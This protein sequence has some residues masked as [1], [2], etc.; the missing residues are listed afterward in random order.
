M[1]RLRDYQLDLLDRVRNALDSG[2]D[3]RVML[4]LPTGGGKTRIAGELLDKLALQIWESRVFR[5]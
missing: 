1:I 3:A 5:G 4:Q 2:P